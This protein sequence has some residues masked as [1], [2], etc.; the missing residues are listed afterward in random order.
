M[1]IAIGGRGFFA[2]NPLL[3]NSDAQRLP[4]IATSPWNA[5]A[6]IREGA[7]NL[8]A[9]APLE[10]FPY[11]ACSGNDF[12]IFQNKYRQLLFGQSNAL[13]VR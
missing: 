9:T 4:L 7:R 3:N 2:K 1:K 12:P 6:M 13:V 11:V 10:V 8:S 5:W